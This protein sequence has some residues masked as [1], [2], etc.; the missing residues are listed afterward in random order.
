M[1]LYG[2]TTSPFVRRIRLFTHSIP[3]PFKAMDIFTEQDR[4]QLRAKNPTLKVPF[5][6]DDEQCIYD[7]RVI[8]R[9]LVDK[10]KLKPLSWS[11]ENLL[12]IIDA[13]NDSLVSLFLLKRSGIDS[14][15]D[16]LFF[17]LQ[18]ERIEQGMQALEDACMQGD[19]NDWHY[20]S[21]CL[22]CLL[23]WIRFRE[24]LDLAA[25]SKLSQF[26]HGHLARKEVIDTDPR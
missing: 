7:S 13:I 19:F 4:A 8:F 6:L 20:P 1:L 23:D 24:L 10:F 12:T 16:K 15:Q 21:I 26:H 18:K 22:F 25:Y 17:N 3:L 5:L 11:Q 14:S 2:S 9:Y